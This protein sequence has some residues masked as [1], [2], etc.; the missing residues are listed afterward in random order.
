MCQAVVVVMN[1]SRHKVCPGSGCIPWHALMQRQ[2]GMSCKCTHCPRP[3]SVA[4]T[5]KAVGQHSRC[6]CHCCVRVLPP[7]VLCQA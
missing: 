2:A 7:C 5:K 3:R 6:S 4:V 1:M